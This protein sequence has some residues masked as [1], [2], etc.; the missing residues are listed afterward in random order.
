MYLQFLFRIL[1]VI[2]L[3]SVYEWVS[4]WIRKNEHVYESKSKN[5]YIINAK[6][7]YYIIIQ[8]DFKGK[9]L[10]SFYSSIFKH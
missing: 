4:Q 9:G 8:F 10:W 7:N 2:Q 1:C 5:F 6:V 3:D